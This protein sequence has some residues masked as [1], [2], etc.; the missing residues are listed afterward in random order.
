MPHRPPGLDTVYNGSKNSTVYNINA[1][2]GEIVNVFGAGG[3]DRQPA[4][5]DPKKQPD[6][7]CPKIV[8]VGMTRYTLTIHNSRTGKLLWSFAYNEWTPNYSDVDL[9]RKHVRPMDNRYIFGRHDGYAFGIE[10]MPD[11]GSGGATAPKYNIKLESPITR[12][13]DVVRYN[14]DLEVLQ[15]DKNNLLILPQ[16]SYRLPKDAGDS[17]EGRTF[18]GYTEHGSFA[19]SEEDFPYITN[20]AP[21]AKCYD[22]T[23]DW[24][25]LSENERRQLLVGIHHTDPNQRIHPNL[26]SLP[27]PSMGIDSNTGGLR[28]QRY[29]SPWIPGQKGLSS[30]TEKESMN[31]GG[32]VMMTLLAIMSVAAVMVGKFGGLDRWKPLGHKLAEPVR[33]FLPMMK[34]LPQLQIQSKEAVNALM[35]KPLPSLPEV[36][37]D[38]V[39]EFDIITPVVEE[40]PKVRFVEE[41]DVVEV[42]KLEEPKDEDGAETAANKPAVSFPKTPEEL[43]P[44]TPEKKPK[45]KRGSRGGVKNK[46]KGSAKT[47]DANT[48]NLEVGEKTDLEKDD[49]SVKLV[50]HH[51]VKG[52]VPGTTVISSGN[53]EEGVNGPKFVLNK[54]EVHEDDLLGRP[55][56]FPFLYHYHP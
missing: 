28:N 39:D 35:D 25:Q 48:S 6:G 33:E 18:V 26:L 24:E 4:G 14:G 20:N 51:K 38:I 31:V 27:A 47:S 13:F 56:P 5:C 55:P 32:M 2:T 17:R 3:W 29:S 10:A 44:A 43:P 34:G 36:E 37:R 42:E 45:R 9:R 50:I 11:G 15:K 22:R 49:G 21:S 54:L 12:I 16:P 41:P 40:A 1:A 7:S 52:G 8:T 46:P 23:Q 19:M 53:V 30:G